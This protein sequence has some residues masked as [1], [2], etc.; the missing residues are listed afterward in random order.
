MILSSAQNHLIPKGICLGLGLFDT[1]L[2]GMATISPDTY[3]SIFHPYLAD[4]P[5][6]FIV[7]TGIIWLFFAA[8]EITAFISRRPERFFFLV[9]MLRL[10]DVPA[11]L[12]YGTLAE[13][14]SL[15][16]RI[17]IYSAPIFNL[18]SGLYFLRRSG[19]KFL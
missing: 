14:A 10:M 1:L 16:S 19:F 7:R 8:S 4:P 17:A 2:G 6:D 9:G 15:F 18:L 5:K 11:D 12:A 13:G 3:A